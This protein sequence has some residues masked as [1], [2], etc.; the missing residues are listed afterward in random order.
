[1][2]VSM[3]ASTIAPTRAQ[4]H[5]QRS[6]WARITA[7]G[8]PERALN[9]PCLSALALPRGAPTFVFGFSERFPRVARPSAR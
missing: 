8:V 5:L 7:K 4:V 9:A 1:V 3:C 6:I 2:L